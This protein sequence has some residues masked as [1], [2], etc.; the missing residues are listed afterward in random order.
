MIRNSFAKKSI[1]DKTV[2]FTREEGLRVLR[3]Q[4]RRGLKRKHESGQEVP[5]MIGKI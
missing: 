1:F 2:K 3:V 5:R 4:Q